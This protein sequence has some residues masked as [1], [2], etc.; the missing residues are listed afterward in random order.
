MIGEVQQATLHQYTGDLSGEWAVTVDGAPYTIATRHTTSGTPI[1]KATHFVGEHLAAT[2]L[3]VEYHQWGSSRY[4][5]NVIGELAGET[6]P[7]D[8]VM[9]TAHLDDM[10]S[11]STAW[12]AIS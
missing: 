7:A 1:G 10:P 11:G 2:G 6:N 5:P 3:T 8:I 12:Q 4:G 9:I